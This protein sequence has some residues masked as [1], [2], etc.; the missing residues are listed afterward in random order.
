MRSRS[1]TGCSKSRISHS[2]SRASRAN[3]LSGFTA[4]GWLTTSSIGRSVIESL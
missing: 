2:R 1:R 4:T 3:S